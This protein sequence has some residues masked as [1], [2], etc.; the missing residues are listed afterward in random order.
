LGDVNFFCLDYFKDL[1]SV[2]TTSGKG[3]FDRLFA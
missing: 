2:F 3:T 1:R